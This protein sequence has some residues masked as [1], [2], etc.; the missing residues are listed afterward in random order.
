MQKK[1]SYIT[2]LWVWSS[3]LDRSEWLEKGSRELFGTV[4]E[5]NVSYFDHTPSF[6]YFADCYLY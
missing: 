1:V 3:L 5:Q 2:V 4:L 6:I